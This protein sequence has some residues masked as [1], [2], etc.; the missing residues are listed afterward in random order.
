MKRARPHSARIRVF[1]RI[2]I[3]NINS[4]ILSS[5]MP[6]LSIRPSWV[7]F[8]SRTCVSDSNTGHKLGSFTTQCDLALIQSGEQELRS[9]QTS[10]SHALNLSGI[11]RAHYVNFRSD[12]ILARIVKYCCCHSDSRNR[13]SSVVN[14]I[15]ITIIK[16]SL[17]YA[18]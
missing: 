14:A 12:G 3:S 4:S 17:P 10:A 1:I 6:L 18:M 9:N 15:F 8:E 2:Q 13:S 7:P 11:K 16:S 5:S